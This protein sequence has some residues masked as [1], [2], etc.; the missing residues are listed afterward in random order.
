MTLRVVRTEKCLVC[1]LEE[2]TRGNSPG[3]ISISE[4]RVALKRVGGLYEKHNEILFG[5]DEAKKAALE[6]AAIVVTTANI[7]E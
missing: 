1:G 7:K 6:W 4:R 3:L 2:G 5:F